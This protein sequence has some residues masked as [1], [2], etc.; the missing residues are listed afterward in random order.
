MKARTIATR[1]SSG[2]PARRVVQRLVEAVAAA[3]ADAG[4]QREVARRRRRIDHAGE[5]RRIRRDHGVI[6]Q[7]ALQPQA[8]HAEVRVLVGEF[9]VARVVGGFRNAP[10][11]AE[12]VP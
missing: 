1:A 2:K 3:R 10:G 12:A 7:A 11:Q 9:Q 8:G 5:R 4:Q 6:A